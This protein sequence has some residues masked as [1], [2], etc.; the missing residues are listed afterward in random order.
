M[1]VFSLIR[2]IAQSL[3]TLTL[4]KLRNSKH[5]KS[6]ICL[7]QFSRALRARKILIENF[8]N[9]TSCLWCGKANKNLT[10]FTQNKNQ[11]LKTALRLYES[12]KH[13]LIALVVSR[14]MSQS[15][16]VFRREA[17]HLLTRLCWQELWLQRLMEK[18]TRAA[19]RRVKRQHNCSHEWLSKR[20]AFKEHE[21][22][23]FFTD[24]T[25]RF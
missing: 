9:L 15:C 1:W 23:S 2:I 5:F 22:S 18:W 25:F 20:I 21:A 17:S 3:I 11:C 6:N 24:F 12:R 8:F 7:K 10:E 19:K 13:F 4:N 16:Q 14:Q